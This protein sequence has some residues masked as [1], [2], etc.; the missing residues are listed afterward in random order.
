MEA[1]DYNLNADDRLTQL[2]RSKRIVTWSQLLCYVKHLPYGRITD[3]TDLSLMLK[4]HTG[5]CS[6]KHAFLK[7]I[8]D[9]NSIA[10]D[11]VIGIYKMTTVNTPGI[12]TGLRE[13]GLEYIPEAHCYLKRESTI[14]DVT[15][16]DSNH[17]FAEDLMEEIHI[18]PDQV[19]T[20]KV[21]YHQ[22]FIKKWLATNPA[23][24]T[25]TFDEVWALREQCIANLSE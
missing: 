10:V 14:I 12:G 20:Y 5:T 11:L 24:T 8:A 13:V 6:T 9:C 19:G 23:I 22:S 4:E 15:G 25:L 7:Q 18:T 21:A 2:V 17:T 3:K 1:G 16:I